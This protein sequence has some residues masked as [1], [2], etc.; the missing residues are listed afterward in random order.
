MNLLPAPRAGS[1]V[2]LLLRRFIKT[3]VSEP[4]RFKYFA[5]ILLDI[6][7]IGLIIMN[8]VKPAQRIIDPL[9]SPFRPLQPIHT[10]RQGYEVFGFAPFWTFDK[11]SN[12]DFNTLTTLAYFGV[13]V[14]SDGNLDKEDR[15]YEVFKSRQ[16]TEL[17]KKAHSSGTRVVL[18]LTNMENPS[19]RGIMDDSQ[20]QERTIEQAVSEVKDRGIDG[21]NVDFE[22]TGDPGPEYRHKFTSFVA[23]LTEKMH[24]AIPDSKV[25]VS[26]Y[27]SAVKEP[28]IYEIGELSRVADGV[29]MM[30]YDFAVA[31]SDNAIPTA[32]LYGHKSGKY[33]YDISTAV[34]DFL[35]AMDPKKL[36]LGVPYYGYNYPV[37]DPE[38]KAE[39]RPSWSY[40][41]RAAA[42]TY[43]IVEE[44]VTPKTE[45]EGWDENGQVG[46]KAYFDSENGTWR[47][48]FSEDKRSLAIKYDFIKSKNL[49]GVGMW[50]LGFDDGKTELWDLLR[51][52]FGNKDLAN[53]QVLAKEIN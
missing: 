44:H 51:E 20:A 52:K 34:E 8:G 36:I 3:T 18:T 32:P 53:N 13:P 2:K 48:I 41:G 10:N 23:R 46:Y 43:A 26:V 25:T 4:S 35:A 17:F 16:A 24:E 22:Y 5:G 7:L 29:F 38:I 37:Y 14:L 33:W 1:R 50:A 11:L 9:V 21:L 30:A 15:G 45:K 28:K 31:G 49:A 12:V 42:Q 40:R 39:T 27:A 19:I 47:M 6:S